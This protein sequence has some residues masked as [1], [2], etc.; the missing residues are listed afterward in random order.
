MGNEQNIKETVPFLSVS[1]MQ[2]SLDFYVKGLGFEIQYQWVLND[3]IMWCKLING[4]GSLMLQEHHQM[5]NGILEG[6]GNV[7]IGISIYFICEDA[8]KIYRAIIDK[9]F[10]ASEPFVGNNMWVTSVNDPDGYSINFESAT[11]V[12]EGTKFSAWV[13]NK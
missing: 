13:K 12:A 4:N 3:R 7:G 10:D 9:G 5:V 2:K 1:D 11:D 8:L 6:K